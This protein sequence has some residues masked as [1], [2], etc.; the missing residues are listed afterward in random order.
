MGVAVE[1]SR[2]DRPS[3]EVHRL[4]AIEAR[5]D[6][7]EATV[8]VLPSRS[9]GLGRVVVEA[10]CR[11]RGVVAFSDGGLVS[12]APNSQFKTTKA[13]NANEA[14]GRTV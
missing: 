14:T 3:T 6:V 10:F 8:L 13:R 12:L 9:E 7:D 1:E 11:G 4:I 5:P 2:Q